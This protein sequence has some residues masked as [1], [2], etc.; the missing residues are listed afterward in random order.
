MAGGFTSNLFSQGLAGCLVHSM[1]SINIYSI[2][3]SMIA[4]CAF[5]LIG[6]LL[7]SVLLSYVNDLIKV[8][9]CLF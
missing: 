1:S 5:R 8:S 3:K 9:I 7:V 6:F 4:M 2:Q